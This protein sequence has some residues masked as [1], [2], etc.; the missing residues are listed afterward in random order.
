MSDAAVNNKE[1]NGFD[2]TT[3]FLYAP[4]SE[5]V[6]I[7][8]PPG[9]GALSGQIWRLNKALYGLKQSPSE[10]YKEMSG[11]LTSLDYVATKSD[12]CIFTKGVT[13]KGTNHII[14]IYLY[15]DDTLITYDNTVAPVWLHDF[16]VIKSKY[17]VTDLGNVDWILNMKITRNR[18]SGTLTLSQEAYVKQLLLEHGYDINTVRTTDNPCDN[19]IANGATSHSE[20]LNAKEHSIYRSII[21]GLSYAALMTRIDICYAVSFLSRALAAPTQKHLIAAKRILRYLAGTAHY[22]MVFGSKGTTEQGI[23]A[24]TDA[25]YGTDPN[26]CKSTGGGIIKYNGNPIVWFSKKQKSVA[27]SSTE[28]EWYALCMVVC[29]AIWVKQ[30]CYEVF[31]APLAPVIF[32]DNQSAIHLSNHDHMHQ[33][34]KHINIKY[35][36]IRDNINNNNIIVKWLP[37]A[38]Q[39]ADILTKTM[40]TKQ[41]QALVAKNLLV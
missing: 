2:V 26:D 35:H 3:A 33:R 36:Y 24:Y 37:T 16:N 13:Q 31:K 29:E 4:L 1:I 32:C 10:W 34:S 7:V 15:V 30:W 39:E 41:F 23:T 11:T 38:K 19:T 14:S 40:V 17:K 18:T 6:Y 20:L 21:G 28:A 25:S 12:P 22:A 8:I 5:V 9:C 27:L